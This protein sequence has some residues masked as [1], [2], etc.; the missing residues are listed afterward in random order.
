MKTRGVPF[1]NRELGQATDA[2]M[3]R[4]WN[5]PARFESTLFRL[6][7]SFQPRTFVV[8]DFRSECLRLSSSRSENSKVEDEEIDRLIKRSDELIQQSKELIDKSH[9]VIDQSS[10]LKELARQVKEK[11]RKKIPP[12]QP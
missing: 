9:E 6:T 10:T 4:C 1:A 11:R 12:G 2:T 8:F 3:E 5:D 7:K